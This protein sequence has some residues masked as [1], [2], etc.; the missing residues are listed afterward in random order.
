MIILMICWRSVFCCFC[1]CAQFSHVLQF[2][3]PFGVQFGMLYGVPGNL[4]NRLN[5]LKGLRFSHFGV[6]FCRYD[7]QARLGECFFIDLFDVWR[8][9]EPLSGSVLGQRCEK[10]KYVKTTEQGVGNSHASHTESY[11]SSPPLKQFKNIPE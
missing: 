3:V 11:G 5:T 8:F 9:L 4:E 1:F 6:P 2:R 10:M 7:F